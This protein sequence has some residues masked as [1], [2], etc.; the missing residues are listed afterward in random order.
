MDPLDTAIPLKLKE[1]LRAFKGYKPL[2]D[3]YKPFY[4]PPSPETIHQQNEDI[5]QKLTTDWANQFTPEQRALIRKGLY[6]EL[7]VTA[8]AD[9]KFNS[10]VM[11]QMYKTLESR[12]NIKTYQ[13]FI[14]QTTSIK[15]L[16]KALNRVLL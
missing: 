12:K 10:Y 4:T 1:R 13:T 11:K 15:A 8:Y 6:Q 14:N 16:K 2:I 9:P 5:K 3:V 7:D